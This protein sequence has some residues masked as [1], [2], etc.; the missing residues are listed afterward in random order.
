M[1]LSKNRLRLFVVLRKA[2]QAYLKASVTEAGAPL[3]AGDNLTVE[4]LVEAAD[5]SRTPD[6]RNGKRFGKPANWIVTNFNI[7]NGSEGVK[8]GLDAYG[9]N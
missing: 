5:F 6:T 1:V 8:Q 3:Y 9:R 7:P 2:F 4:M